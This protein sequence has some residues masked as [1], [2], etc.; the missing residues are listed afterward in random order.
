MSS[1]PRSRWSLLTYENA[2]SPFAPALD[3]LLLKRDKL[4]AVAL[5]HTA[6]FSS[7]IQRGSSHEACLVD[8]VDIKVALGH[9]LPAA[10]LCRHESKQTQRQQFA[11]VPPT[12]AHCFL[13]MRQR[14]DAVGVKSEKYK[15]IE[16]LDK[17][18]FTSNV[19]ARLV[20]RALLSVT[21]CKQTTCKITQRL[22][23]TLMRA[24]FWCS[25]H[26]ARNRLQYLCVV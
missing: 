15:A 10:V 17:D 18:G 26:S 20:I 12:L 5:A 23:L 1:P 2:C 13:G 19:P 6:G 22:C 11:H 7:T 14:S 9:V 8:N 25:E 3:S 4:Q 21:N 16:H 24:S